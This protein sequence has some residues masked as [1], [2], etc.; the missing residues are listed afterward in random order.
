M[1]E[2]DDIRALLARTPMPEID[3]IRALKTNWLYCLLVQVRDDTPEETQRNVEQC[4]PIYVRHHATIVDLTASFQFIAF[5]VH[6]EA[7]K[8]CRDRSRA[9]AKELLAECGD[10]LRMVAFDGD[11]AYGNIGTD[12]RM[13]YT[14]FVPKFDRF[15]GAL[16]NTEFGRIT[17]LESLP[18]GRESRHE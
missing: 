12:Q 16:L 8:E 5:G 13:N 3:D 15:L 2:I 9:A 14:V 11:M 18:N 6:G 1:A 10:T 7:K 17:E 4:V